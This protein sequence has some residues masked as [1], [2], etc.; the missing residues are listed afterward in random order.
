MIL[1]ILF[2]AVVAFIVYKIIAAIA[3]GIS[4]R[5]HDKRQKEIA[6]AKVEKAAQQAEVFQQKLSGTKEY[7]T[8][9][10]VDPQAQLEEF[11]AKKRAG[12][13]YAGIVRMALEEDNY[14][15][16]YW[17]ISHDDLRDPADLRQAAADTVRYRDLL[18]GQDWADMTADILLLGEEPDVEVR[19]QER[20]EPEVLQTVR[21]AV[22]EKD[23]ARI[24]P[25]L[26]D[27]RRAPY[28]TAPDSELLLLALLPR[29]SMYEDAAEMLWGLNRKSYLAATRSYWANKHLGDLKYRYD[30]YYQKR[31]A[32][33]WQGTN[34]PMYVRFKNDAFREAAQRL[35]QY[36]SSAAFRA[37]E[38]L[39]PP[40]GVGGFRILRELIGADAEAEALFR[41]DRAATNAWYHVLLDAWKNRGDPLGPVMLQEQLRLQNECLET[42][43]SGENRDFA[44][45]ALGVT[46]KLP[47]LD[48]TGGLFCFYLLGHP[49]SFFGRDGFYMD[50]MWDICETVSAEGGIPMN[51]LQAFLR[52]ADGFRLRQIDNPAVVL[53]NRAVPRV[54]YSLG[55][56]PWTYSE[57]HKCHEAE[58]GWSEKQM[59]YRMRFPADTIECLD[60]GYVCVSGIEGR[61]SD[62]DPDYTIKGD[63]AF[64]TYRHME[65]R[66]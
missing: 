4:D 54:I 23:F 5:K 25:A 2:V 60:D 64:R 44:L 45:N 7:R 65:F 19:W 43:L 42:C 18:T 27:D 10:T 52:D 59:I 63:V 11:L 13:D 8:G 41:H 55:G 15:A 3:E 46:E 37:L 57:F 9:K 35:Y 40:E 49:E 1:K 17:L 66:W 28:G 39:S 12:A 16:K 58:G 21:K 6:A 30:A 29:I 32:N 53:G 48:E 38:V 36:R 61:P 20:R 50:R 14:F 22:E 26:N 47:M 24:C 34:A 56:K 33:S 62:S 51:V 31:T